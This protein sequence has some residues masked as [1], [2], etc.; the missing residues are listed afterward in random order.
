MSKKS[1]VIYGE[2]NSGTNYLET[3]LTGESHH[4]YHDI[5][6]FEIPCDNSSILEKRP[7]IFGSKHFFGYYDDQ[8]KSKGR[9]NIF[10]GIVRNP[11]DWLVACNKSKHHIPPENHEMKDFLTNEWY[12]I[13][14]NKKHVDYG[15]EKIQD[16][17][18]KNGMRYKNVFEMR[19][20]KIKY[21]C[22]TMPSL[23]KKTKNYELIRYEDLCFDPWS[24]IAKISKKYFLPMNMPIMEPIEKNPYEID[25]DIK[26]I[27]DNNVD[28]RAESLVGYARRS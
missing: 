15:K 21:L 18:F 7:S 25:P 17:N 12:S 24:I 22:Q 27:I 26:Q 3:I 28:W 10:I 20:A 13:E 9:N 23:T 1:F 4:L 11:Y 6:A 19:S 8:I 14:H 16:R 5:S 2:R